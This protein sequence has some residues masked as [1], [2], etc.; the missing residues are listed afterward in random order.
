MQILTYKYRMYPTPG[1]ERL[2]DRALSIGWRIWNDACHQRDALYKAG[3]KLHWQQQAKLWRGYRNQHEE[4]QILPSATV[5]KIIERVDWAYRSFFALRKNG[6]ESARKPGEKPRRDFNTLDYRYILKPAVE[7]EPRRTAG[8]GCKFT[9]EREGVARLRLMHIGDIR[10]HQHRP[11]AAGWLIKHILVKRDKNGWWHCYLQI[12]SEAEAQAQQFDLPS[13]A[14]GI[15]MG[16]VNLITVFSWNFDRQQTAGEDMGGEPATT[17]ESLQAHPH[18]YT[19]LQEKRTAYQQQTDRQRRAANPDNYNPDGT[20]KEGAV[21]WRKSNRQ[22]AVEAE[23]RRMEA[24]IARQRE[25]FW[26]QVTDDLTRNYRFIAIE[27][28]KLKFMQQNGK[29]AKH[30][31]DAALA[32]FRNLLIE[33][34]ARRGV[35]VEVVN[36]AY[37]SQTCAECGYVDA[38]NRPDQATFCCLECGH[39]NNADVNAARNILAKGLAQYA[40][41]SANAEAG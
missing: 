35:V 25:Y 9:P 12:Q 33:K 11:I 36:P 6:H 16:L 28:L 23:Q 22:R 41:R 8:A 17:F 2:L 34:A 13:S 18:W 15:D 24:R 27:D 4:L 14:A 20:V 26:Q 37:T 39:E 31:Y 40:A 38:D 30:T 29:L 5:D 7:G 19:T 10:V 32:R 21:I 3:E 1:Q